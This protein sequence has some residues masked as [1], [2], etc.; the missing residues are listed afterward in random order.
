MPLFRP[1]NA[2]LVS[3]FFSCEIVARSV[4]TGA[5]HNC[6]RVQ[7]GVIVCC[8]CAASKT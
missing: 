7:R 1:A 8:A 4:D 3:Y 2:A 6:T 5:D